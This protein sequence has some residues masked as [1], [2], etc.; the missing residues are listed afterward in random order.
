MCLC[1]ESFCIWV[2]SALFLQALGS[3]VG[4]IQLYNNRITKGLMD[5]LLHSIVFQHRI[6]ASRW[7]KYIGLERIREQGLEQEVYSVL[8]QKI[9]SDPLLV[10][11]KSIGITVESLGMNKSMWDTFESQLQDPCEKRRTQ[12]VL[13]LA[14]LGLRHKLILCQLLNM[15][16]TDQSESVRIQIVRLF[17]SLDLKDSSV[18]RNLKEKE[19]GMGSLAREA[20][21]ALKILEQSM[22]KPKQN[23]LVVRDSI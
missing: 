13:A 4:Q 12:A 1:C 3:L 8:K 11:R 5:Q 15:L 21:K 14:A 7:L 2:Q 6:Q 10:I 22:A 20:S 17:C 16:D 23:P 18:L 9:H 19:Q